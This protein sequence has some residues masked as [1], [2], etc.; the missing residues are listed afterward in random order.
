MSD[1]KVSWFNFTNILV[2]IAVIIQ[3]TQWAYIIGIDNKMFVHLTNAELHVPRSTV[4]SKDEFNFY[5][6]MRDRQMSE[7]KDSL[8][9]VDGMLQ[10][11][12]KIK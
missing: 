9:R 7:I 1:E 12:L 11:Y 2:S 5:Q 8:E 3:T 10:K 4:I 6:M